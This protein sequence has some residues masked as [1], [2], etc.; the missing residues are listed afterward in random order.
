MIENIRYENLGC[1]QMTYLG[2]V[3]GAK[4]LSHLILI[5][6][7]TVKEINREKGVFY[8]GKGCI[9][10]AWSAPGRHSPSGPQRLAGFVAVKPQSLIFLLT[11][12]PEKVTII[13]T[14]TNLK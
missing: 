8:E 3:V 2:G 13:A 14:I 7:E 12:P 6:F 9:S 4:N 5:L 11:R 1:P 10:K